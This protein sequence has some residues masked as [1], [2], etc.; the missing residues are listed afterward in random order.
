M[1]ESYDNTVASF[2]GEEIAVDLPYAELALRHLNEFVAGEPPCARIKDTELRLDLALIALDPK[3]IIN[4]VNAKFADR[5]VFTKDYKPT[6]M[7]RILSGLRMDISDKYGGWFPQMGKNWD[8]DTVGGLPHIDTGSGWE[9]PKATFPDEVPGLT[10]DNGQE[11]RVGVIDGQLF[12]NNEL[13]F[14]YFPLDA[15][16]VLVPAEGENSWLAGHSAF[17]AGKILERAPGAKLEFR[18]TLQLKD[19][20]PKARVWDVARGMAG[21]LTS[22]V[23]ILNLSIG[24]YVPDAQPP[25]V[26]ERATEVLSRHGILLVA[27]AGNHGAG[28]APFG[29]KSNAP[30][31]PA[32]SPGVVAV[33]AVQRGKDRYEP[34]SFS[35]QAPWIN[36]VAPGFQVTSTYLT[37]KVRF[38]L[39][40]GLPPLPDPPVQE[41]FGH[42]RWSGTSFAA[43]TIS[44]E[45]AKKVSAGGM[46]PQQALEVLRTQDP[47]AHGGIGRYITP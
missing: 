3:R 12:P 26:L 23:K 27:A 28:D 21:F 13:A 2:S 22:N 15:D 34:A 46:T 47:D 24:C 1:T 14:R 6:E 29:L 25:F 7:D 5:F 45:I 19:G 18:G 41:F 10:P 33:G 4:V 17:V 43:A 39:I 30:I 8:S 9:Y 40:D 37:G 38:T 44:G 32:A 36:L 20:V 16:S 35:P 42:A 11:L 31:Y